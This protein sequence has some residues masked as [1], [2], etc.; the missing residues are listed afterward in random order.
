MDKTIGIFVFG[1][2]IGGFCMILAEAYDNTKEREQIM[3]TITASNFKNYPYRTI[4][5]Y[6]IE[7]VELIETVCEQVFNEQFISE[8]MCFN[9]VEM[10]IY[11]PE[12]SI[13]LLVQALQNY[14]GDGLLIHKC[15]TRI[16]RGC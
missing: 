5:L 12:S 15:I 14:A 16:V 13:G 11:L 6:T 1:M 2:A 9:Y 8:T 10:E 7:E 3:K 4:L